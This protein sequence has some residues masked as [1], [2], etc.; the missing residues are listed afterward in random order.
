[1]SKKYDEHILKTIEDMNRIF[2]TKGKVLPMCPDEIEEV[3]SDL[4]REIRDRAIIAL[5][6]K[7][8]MAGMELTY[9]DI[10]LLIDGDSSEKEYENEKNTSHLR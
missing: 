8:N 3:D 10:R 6:Q 2:P 5:I 9:G 7:A 1:M 4:R